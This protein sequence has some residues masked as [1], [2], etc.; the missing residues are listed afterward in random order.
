MIVNSHSFIGTSF[1]VLGFRICDMLSLINFSMYNLN[2]QDYA[3]KLLSHY[4]SSLKS[5]PS[6][7]WFNITLFDLLVFSHTYKL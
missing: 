1:D 5:L 2:I 7:N 6:M 3:A 4:Q